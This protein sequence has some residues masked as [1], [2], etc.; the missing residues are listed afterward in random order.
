MAQKPDYFEK[1]RSLSN[2]PS[3]PVIHSSPRVSVSPPEEAP[4]GSTSQQTRKKRII[5]T[6]TLAG[7]VVL[8]LVLGILLS[9]P[10][11][12]K[13]FAGQAVAQGGQPAQAAAA[14][15]PFQCQSCVWEGARLNC[16]N[17]DLTLPLLTAVG[18]IAGQIEAQA[19][20]QA[21]Q[22][23]LPD[24]FRRPTSTTF[25]FEA[26]R[27]NNQANTGE[28]GVSCGGACQITLPDGSQ[29]GNVHIGSGIALH[30]SAEYSGYIM[31][32]ATAI[33]TR[34]SADG[35]RF[36]RRQS[37]NLLGICQRD[38][39]WYYD[40]NYGCT[41]AFTPVET[42]VLLA[43]YE[44]RGRQV[45]SVVPLSVPPA[46]QAPEPVAEEEAAPQEPVDTTRLL[47][48]GGGLV[49]KS[50]DGGTTWTRLNDRSGLESVSRV[51]LFGATCSAPNA[52]AFYSG[53]TIY[54]TV[55]GGHIWGTDTLGEDLTVIKDLSCRKN[56]AR[57]DC[58]AVTRQGNLGGWFE[59]TLLG[60]PF[61][62]T[63]RSYPIPQD[64][65]EGFRSVSCSG[66]RDCLGITTTSQ[67]S[68][69]QPARRN[70]WTPIPVSVGQ[71]INDL[72]CSYNPVNHQAGPRLFCIAVGYT[73]QRA[74]VLRSTTPD[75]EWGEPL[76][77]WQESN[78]LS[79][80]KV[81]CFTETCLAL[82]SYVNE[83]NSRKTK[84]YQSTDQGRTWRAVVLPDAVGE[85]LL[86]EIACTASGSGCWAVGREGLILKSTNGGE[87]WREQALPPEI[88]RINP[89]LFSIAVMEEP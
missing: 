57:D 38:G 41:K 36:D 12:G 30:D 5:L 14:N 64:R 33:R 75:T 4:Q 72:W 68:L 86:D 13:T 42:D 46:E 67:L 25:Q 69:F 32:S 65:Q 48:V 1:L 58:T 8:L 66:N 77:L 88:V 73:G 52:C 71:E 43:S 20:P 19:A 59:S 18:E 6:S 84:I 62:S 56:G 55:D 51:N 37:T 9:G 3:P 70:I 44:L 61:T 85:V 89:R 34:F 31:Y 27:Y 74:V 45:Q 28:I 63:T 22:P 49:I 16:Q 81:T 24:V 39:Q 53:R 79:F 40:D 17:C 54:R 78:L 2:T 83:H 21:E 87:T 80:E 60:V 47:A 11:G 7:G 50:E 29:I 82:G 23:P 10:S 35:P 76:V 26:D 15:A